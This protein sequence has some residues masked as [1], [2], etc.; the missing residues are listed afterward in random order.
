[1]SSEFF[2]K[3]RSFLEPGA[4]VSA[5]Q[6]GALWGNSPGLCFLAVCQT[7]ITGPGAGRRKGAGTT[8]VVVGR[9]RENLDTI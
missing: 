1:M 8:W 2:P 3:R 6:R 9:R 4:Q 5:R 7:L